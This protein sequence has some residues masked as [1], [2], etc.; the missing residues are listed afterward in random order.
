MRADLTGAVARVLA[1]MTAE[2]VTVTDA[3]TEALLA[4][5]DLVTRARTAVD[6]DYAGN[7]IDAHAPEMP[8]RFAKQ[9]AQVVRGAVAVGMDRREAMR[10]AVRC[11]RDSMPPLRLAI[12][13]DVAAHPGASTA[14]VRKRVGKPRATVDRELQALHMLDALTTDEEEEVRAGREVTVWRYT[15]ADDIDPGALDPDAL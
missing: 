6:R 4:A 13:D 9:L 5:A 1:E 10:L 15:L 3:E 11:A 14:E 8:T 12:L 2:P 7:V